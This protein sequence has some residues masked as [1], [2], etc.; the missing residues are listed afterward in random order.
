MLGAKFFD[1]TYYNNAYYAK[2][3]GVP[4]KEINSLEV[5][6][7]FLVNFSLHVTEDMYSRYYNELINHAVSSTCAC[8]TSKSAGDFHTSSPCLT[9]LP[10]PNS[11]CYRPT[12]TCLPPLL[13][14]LR[15]GVHISPP[16]SPVAHVSEHVGHVAQAVVSPALVCPPTPPTVQPTTQASLAH[17]HAV[18]ADVERFTY[19]S[20][21][22][23]ET[24][25][26]TEQSHSRMPA[27]TRS[28]VAPYMV[29]PL[30]AVMATHQMAWDR[31]PGGALLHHYAPPKSCMLMQSK[32]LPH[33]PVMVTSGSLPFA[34]VHDPNTR[35]PQLFYPQHHYNVQVL[36]T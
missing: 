27:G 29:G 12:L 2:V 8:C 6:F 30:G 32:G 35:N 16:V 18:N 20:G 11:Q 10:P 26:V 1:D 15:T 31:A 3:G 4:C 17:P 5:E 21:G 24:G 33:G 36:H 14:F 13:F 19:Y 28:H 9:R 22:A 34:P 25:A 23:Y 7:L